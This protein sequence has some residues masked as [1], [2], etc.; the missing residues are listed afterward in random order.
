MYRAASGIAV[1][2]TE[3]IVS[4][5]VQSARCLPDTPLVGMRNFFTVPPA[6]CPSPAAP[7]A[8]HRHTAGTIAA[9]RAAACC[10]DAS[11]QLAASTLMT[12][13][14]ERPS[15]KRVHMRTCPVQ[16]THRHR[17]TQGYLHM[18]A[19]AHH[20]F[21][22][23]FSSFSAGLHA[24]TI[25]NE[26]PSQHCAYALAFSPHFF[27]ACCFSLYRHAARWRNGHQSPELVLST[28]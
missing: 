16:N 15:V 27:I 26:R 25:E 10:K 23:W 20:S 7:V 12:V 9:A 13:T 18:H 3:R 2:S 6:A 22:H 28:S 8:R 21:K 1:Y 19:G 4:C 14:L 17:H 5:I 24:Q 11:S